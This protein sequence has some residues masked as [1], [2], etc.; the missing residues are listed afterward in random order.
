MGGLEN[1]TL[2]IFWLVMSSLRWLMSL[3]YV[4]THR[5]VSSDLDSQRVLVAGYVGWFVDLS[6][7]SCIAEEEADRDNEMQC[8]M[9]T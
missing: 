5:C 2:V 8:S 7:I 4:D 3:V 6:R 1:L 9:S